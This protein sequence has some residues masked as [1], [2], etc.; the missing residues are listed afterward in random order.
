MTTWP[1]SVVHPHTPSTWMGDFPEGRML[2]HCNTCA[3]TLLRWLKGTP[4]PWTWKFPK[5][6]W[7]C[8]SQM[9]TRCGSTI[10]KKTHACAVWLRSRTKAHCNGHIWKDRKGIRPLGFCPRRLARGPRSLC[11]ASTSWP[12][13]ARSILGPPHSSAT[14]VRLNDHG[15]RWSKNQTP[16]SGSGVVRHELQ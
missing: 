2:S 1:S 4:A 5:V 14:V 7:R 8:L 15:V 11:S 3:V 13:G 16:E 12:P 6:K 10:M 9:S